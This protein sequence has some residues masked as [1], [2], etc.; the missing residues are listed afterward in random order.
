[1]TRWLSTFAVLAALG[2][3]E[4]AASARCLTLEQVHG[5]HPRYHVIGGRHCWHA[6]NRGPGVT[7]GGIHAAPAT[8][9][10]AEKVRLQDCEQQAMKLDSNEKRTFL[11]QCMSNVGR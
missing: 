7:K 1:M 8:A 3:S 2:V 6:P 5:G 11:K 9:S 10:A 4:H